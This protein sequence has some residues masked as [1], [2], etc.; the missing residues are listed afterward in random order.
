ML[1]QDEQIALFVDAI[2]KDALKLC[3]EIE[4]D[5]KK[6]YSEEVKKLEDAAK[7]E[8]DSKTA[9]AE[10]RIMSDI[11]R[12]AAADKS[13]YRHELY[14]RREEL[15]GEVFLK[16][17]QQLKEF[18]L[19]DEYDAFL[20]SSI[21]R[22]CRLIGSDI[23]LYVKPEDYEKTCAAAK[24]SGLECVINEDKSIRIGGI[25]AKTNDGSKTADDTLDERLAEQRDW[26]LLYSGSHLNI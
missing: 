9:Y 24:E 26:F 7:R 2:N 1:S 22:M 20:I 10:S 19:G 23:T 14:K 25:R 15:T 8:L 6:L 3:K 13:L 5:A 17:E 4:K 12:K 21:K 11:N 18:T 16:A